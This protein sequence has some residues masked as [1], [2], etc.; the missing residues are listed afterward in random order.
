MTESLTFQRARKPEEISIRREAI[1][2]AAAELFDEAGP[3]GT[4]LNAIAARAGFTKSNVYRYFESR[5]A[6]LLELFRIDFAGLVEELEANLARV[7]RG[8]IA[9]VARI[10]AAAFVK[11][12]RACRLLAI[13]AGVLERNISEEAVIALKTEML[14]LSSRIAIALHG[15]L[16]DL[17]VDDCGWAGSVVGTFVSGLWPAA[18]PSPMVAAVLARPEFALMK[19]TVGRDLERMIFVTLRGLSN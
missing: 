15:P 5:E 9:A 2:A 17:S 18:N 14:G 1:L 3:E 7:K 11:R 10:C 4:G 12:P 16:P 19:P 8:D 6:V 13:L